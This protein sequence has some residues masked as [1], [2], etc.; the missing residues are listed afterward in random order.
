MLFAKGQMENICGCMGHPTSAAASL[1]HCFV[2]KV[3]AGNTHVTD[4]SCG[5]IKLY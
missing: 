3:A 5:L 4:S 2:V 1:L